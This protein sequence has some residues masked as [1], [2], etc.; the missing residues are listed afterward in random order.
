MLSYPQKQE[1]V[2]HVEQTGAQK[3]AK[4]LKVLV[5]ITFVCNLIVLFFV[6][7][8][9]GLRQEGGWLALR[10]AMEGSGLPK[11][12]I[13]LGGCWQYLFRFWREPYTA[14]LTIFLW[15]C[16]AC[17]AIVLWQ[18]GRVLDTIIAG[19]PF[20]DRN[21]RSLKVAAGCFF[22]ISLSALVRLFIQ[23]GWFRRATAYNALFIPVFAMAGMLCLVM[24]ALFRQAAELKEDSDLTI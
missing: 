22:V 16:G 14:V 3:L 11:P 13:F 9:A 7:G 20:Q 21:A 1:G 8:L 6:P 19:N 10:E 4:I 15:A 18:A 23:L 24:A 17:T 12:L 5:L 2:T